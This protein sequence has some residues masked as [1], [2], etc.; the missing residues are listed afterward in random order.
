[1]KI[2]PWRLSPEWF[3][4]SACN[5]SRCKRQ[6][7]PEWCWMLHQTT[8][9]HLKAPKWIDTLQRLVGQDLLG[10]GCT[11]SWAN[12]QGPL[13]SLVFV[14]WLSWGLFVH[15]CYTKKIPTESMVSYS[16]PFDGCISHP[17]CQGT[18]R[19]KSPWKSWKSPGHP[20]CIGSPP[21]SSKGVEFGSV[22]NR[23]QQKHTTDR[24]F[25]RE[26]L[27]NFRSWRQVDVKYK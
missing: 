16:H 20:M 19:L 17:A 24:F 21:N 27:Q 6:G 9:G 4:A 14:S 3:L 1:M 22:A 13:M 15:A 7:L 18:R 26:S 23:R 2:S 12:I 10:K 5:L 8:V 25:V 11:P